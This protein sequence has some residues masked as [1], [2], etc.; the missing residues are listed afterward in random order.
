MKGGN[1]GNGTG[2]G[3]FEKADLKVDELERG[4]TRI[5]I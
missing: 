1:V 2:R 5:R 4:E 3:G